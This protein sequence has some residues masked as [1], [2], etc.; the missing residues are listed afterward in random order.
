M[1]PGRKI[2]RRRQR[3]DRPPEGCRRRRPRSGRISDAGFRC[4]RFAGSACRSRAETDLQHARLCAPGAE[5]P[6]ALVA[7]LRRHP[8][9][10][11][12][13]RS[14]RS[15]GQ[16]LDRQG[17][18]RGARRLQSAAQ[19][20]QGSEGQ[21]RRVARRGRRTGDPDPARSRT[22]VQGRHQEAGRGHAGRS[23]RA[24]TA[25]QARHPRQ[26]RRY[27]VRRPGRRRRAQIPG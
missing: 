27:E 2:D 23:A 19:A 14:R 15:A 21:A 20:L 9:S 18:F 26:R 16:H 22:R 17:R 13:D 3:R 1:D 5:R 25:R 11:A 6:D 10:R 8:L 4:R 12:P 24:A 7:S